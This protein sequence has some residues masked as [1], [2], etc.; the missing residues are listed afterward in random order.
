MRLGY[1][2]PS[3]QDPDLTA[4]LHALHGAGAERIWEERDPGEQSRQPL[5]DDLLLHLRH[6]D[7]LIVRRL[8]RLARSMHHLAQTV[9]TIHERGA[10]LISLTDAIDTTE[11]DGRAFFHAVGIA[12][13]LERALLAEDTITGLNDARDRGVQLGRPRVLTPEQ[14]E[15]ARRLL[16]EPGATTTSVAQ[17]LAVSR[18]T[19]HRRVLPAVED[20]GTALPPTTPPTEATRGGKHAT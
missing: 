11:S 4:Q 1:A 18:S 3:R 15:Q 5:L 14:I 13:D 20:A 2:R 12:D 9:T 7:I 17:H 10:D 8:D 6:G 19:I 16:T